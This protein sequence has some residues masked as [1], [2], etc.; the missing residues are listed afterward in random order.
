MRSQNVGPFGR[1]VYV[2]GDV[3]GEGGR[4]R[5]RGRERETDSTIQALPKSLTIEPL[6]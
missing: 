3:G 1:G 2:Y 6:E 4:R 5:E